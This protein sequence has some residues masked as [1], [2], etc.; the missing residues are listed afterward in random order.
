MR[1]ALVL[2]V[3]FACACRS[4]SGV[5]TDAGPAVLGSTDL[6][7]AKKPPALRV[8]HAATPALPDL[9]ILEAHEAPAKLP[10]G[11]SR[12]LFGSTCLGVWNGSE[13]SATGCARSALLF[14]HDGNGAE[15][16]VPVAAI[17]PPAAGLPSVVDHRLDKTESPARN[18]GKAP[19][20]TAFAMATAIDHAIARWRGDPPRVSAA[21]LWSRY[22]TPYETKSITS[23]VGQTLA[24]EDL[25][26]FDVQEATQ[27]LACDD[28]GPPGKCGLAP[29][30]QRIAKTASTPTA[31]FTH[32]A[33]MDDPSVSAI[34]H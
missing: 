32:V 11:I 23:N 7:P 17:A 2:F 29:N 9:P 28:G 25:W 15:P 4:A 19:A 10:F 6:T 34:E 31:R 22:H 14:G 30:P 26:P 13:V 33:Y 16:L 20:C 12:S 1:V 24:S 21:E 8:P 5:T 27:M 18:Q 3:S